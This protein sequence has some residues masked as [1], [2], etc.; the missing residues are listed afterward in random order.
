MLRLAF[1]TRLGADVELDAEAAD[2]EDDTGRDGG[3]DAASGLY[4]RK[5]KSP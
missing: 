2:A 5:S 4:E 1:G 3:S